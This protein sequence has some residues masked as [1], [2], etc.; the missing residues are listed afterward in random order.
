MVQQLEEPSIKPCHL[1]VIFALGIES[2]CFE[3]LLA[4]LVS[5]RGN[6]FVAREGGLHGRRV[7]VIVSGAGR[8][9]ARR[10][11]E[12]LIDGH[13]P[14]RVISAGLAGALSPSLK[15]NDILV[16]DRLLDTAGAELPIE[17][18]AGLLSS[19]E[20]PN[21]H[22]G[23]LLTLD[24]VVHR[25]SDKALLFERRGAL[26]ADMEALAVAEV[27]L[28][29]QVPFSAIRVIGDAA[30]EALPRD[31]EHLARQR[32]FAARLGAAIA[33]VWRR[34]ASVKDMYRLRENTLVAS[35]RLA[36]FLASAVDT[37]AAS[38]ENSEP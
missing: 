24:R 22:R 25:P 30:D 32:T 16:A 33:A 35:D 7:V 2:G 38:R 20:R 28:R 10:A 31:V 18:P 14:R 15:R 27:C 3:D 11:T 29:R 37:L 9:N 36:R 8:K 13:R 4:G 1:G 21:V 6:G 34:P 17:L 12:I 5:I 23:A 26:A 19:L